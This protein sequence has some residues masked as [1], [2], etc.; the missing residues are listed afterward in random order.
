MTLNQTEGSADIA[1][2]LFNQFGERM[3]AFAVNAW[4]FSEDD[5]WDVIYETL[6]YLAKV[7]HRYDVSDEKRLKNLVITSFNN[8]LR[9]RYRDNQRKPAIILFDNLDEFEAIEV[10]AFEGTATEAVTAALNRLEDWERMLLIQR[11]TNVPYA[12]I[13]QLTG[14]P[15]SQ[16]KVYHKRVLQKLENIV[17]EILKETQNASGKKVDN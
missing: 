2:R 3:F 12:S 6:F 10:E 8:R 7:F 5:A 11:A 13:A 1:E 17:K 14:K 4:K 9:N 15:E 16:L